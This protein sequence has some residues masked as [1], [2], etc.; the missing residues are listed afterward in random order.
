MAKWV[1]CVLAGL[2]AAKSNF[3]RELESCVLKGEDEM[4]RSIFDSFVEQG[5]VANDVEEIKEKYQVFRRQ[6]VDGMVDAVINQ[7]GIGEEDAREAKKHP[8]A[9]HITYDTYKLLLGSS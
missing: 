9:F 4:E 3:T 8:E 2:T 7:L 1:L 6:W 5:I